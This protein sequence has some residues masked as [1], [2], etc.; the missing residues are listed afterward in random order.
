MQ[1]LT[2]LINILLIFF[3]FVPKQYGQIKGRTKLLGRITYQSSQNIYVSFESTEGI[4]K[5]DT[6]YVE[7]NRR[8]LPAI[9]VE[10]IS[11]ISCAGKKII[12]GEL[13]SEDKIIAFVKVEQKSTKD[14]VANDTRSQIKTT[15]EKNI[16][17][18]VR[19]K[20]TSRFRDSG[21]QKISGKFSMQSYS[22]LTNIDNRLNYQN[23]RYT[24]S[25]DANNIGDSKLSYSN[26]VMFSYRADQW[27][28]LSSNLGQAIRIYDL[29][30]NYK[31][32]KGT[33]LWVGRHLNS[34]ISNISAMDGIQFEKYFGSFYSGIAVGS[35]PNFSDMGLNIKLFETGLYF[36]KRDSLGNGAMENTFSIFQQTNDLK[37]DRRFLYL[38]HTDNI[39]KNVNIFASTEVDLYKKVN[40]KGT[41]DFSLTSLF[42]M[43]RYSPM[44]KLSLSLFYDARKNVIYYETFKSF[45]DS[46]IDRETRQGLRARINYRP[47]NLIFVGINA[48]YS[49]QKG[50]L[51]PSRNI[52]GYL[53]ISRIPFVKINTSFSYTK[54]ISGYIKGNIAGCRISK[55]LF[56]DFVSVSLEYRKINY[57]FNNS[58][59]KTEQNSVDGDLSL[60]FT[61]YF[62]LI[63]SYDGEFEKKNTF[64]RLFFGCTTRF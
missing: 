51:T 64:N 1:M 33:N 53:S 20:F 49:Y 32:N 22:N 17:E 45:L 47:F 42:F 50:D 4:K 43:T 38:Q 18:K 19:T 24:F 31:F 26:Y 35:R 55:Y 23:W 40:L 30:L 57:Y 6:L 36:G 37:I 59:Y 16:S 3:V 9:H 56:D 60:N 58:S 54:L 61:K 25:L 48:G 11:S 14:I 44:T 7:R 46:A 34:K 12:R 62:S 39:F 21:K 28:N 52:A 5:G 27:N 15:K 10:Y 13:F 41:N 63:L 29:S 8:L 2:Y